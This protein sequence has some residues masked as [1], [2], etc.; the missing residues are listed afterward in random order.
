MMETAIS[1]LE[2]GGVGFQVFGPA[3][4]AQNLGLRLGRGFSI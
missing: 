1:G 3:A 4:M 2:F